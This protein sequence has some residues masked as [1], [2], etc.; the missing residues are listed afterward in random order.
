MIQC[1]ATFLIHSD[2]GVMLKRRSCKLYTLLLLPQV[3]NI[4][5]K[6]PEN[7]LHPFYFSHV[8]ID[9]IDTFTYIFALLLFYLTL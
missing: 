9:K 1:Y 3:K 8:I 4:L 6:H 7:F 2:K 5:Q